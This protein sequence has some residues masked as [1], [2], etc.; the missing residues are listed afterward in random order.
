MQP[1]SEAIQ[2]PGGDGAGVAS[3]RYPPPGPRKW[4]CI[5]AGRPGA[6]FCCLP[7]AGELRLN[8]HFGLFTNFRAA[9]AAGT[10]LVITC[11][12]D[13]GRTTCPGGAVA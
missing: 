6:G 9:A 5:E 10:L 1:G 3:S 12:E 13:G 7:I 4:P 8:T 2:R 11:D